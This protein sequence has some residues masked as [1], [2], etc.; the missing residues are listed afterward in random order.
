V[1]LVADGDIIPDD[2]VVAAFGNDETMLAVVFELV[3]FY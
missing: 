1:A 2:V 3:A